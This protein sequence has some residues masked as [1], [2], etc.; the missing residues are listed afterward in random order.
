M[1]CQAGRICAQAVP[2]DV[3]DLLG[4]VAGSLTVMGYAGRDREEADG[5]LWLARCACGN[6][7][8]YRAKWLKKRS[9]KR[10]GTCCGECERFGPGLKAEWSVPRRAWH[11]HYRLYQRYGMTL[12]Y[13]EYEEILAKA[14]AGAVLWPR[15]AGASRLC[16]AI[17]FRSSLIFVVIEDG[18]LVT[19][20]PPTGRNS[21]RALGP[22]S[23]PL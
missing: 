2:D 15:E 13:G 20:L 7:E 17:Q 9:A 18:H 3:Q 8:V 12:R 22:W 21:C 19:A 16:C 1:H 4:L 11:F 5:H 10:T 6:R 14:R 23:G